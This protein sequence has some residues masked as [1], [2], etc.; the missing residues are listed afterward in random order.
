M[1]DGKD[2]D[3]NEKSLEETSLE[4]EVIA[5]STYHHNHQQQ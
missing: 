2:K 4:Q 3:A 1:I 5:L